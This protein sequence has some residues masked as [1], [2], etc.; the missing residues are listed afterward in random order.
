MSFLKDNKI[1]AVCFDIDGTLY[2]IK[3]MNAYLFK[4]F[5]KHPIFS[6]KYNNMRQKMRKL[7]GFDK[8]ET[9]SKDD[10]R[11]KEYRILYNKFNQVK[12]DKYKKDLETKFFKNWDRDVKNLNP[13]NNMKESLE[14]LKKNGYTVAVLSDFPLS[15]KL[16]A[17][18]IKD[19]IDYAASSEDFGYLKP[20]ATVFHALAS[21]LKLQPEEILFVGDS[22]HKDVLG[23]SNIGMKTMLINKKEKEENN[24][25]DFQLSSFDNFIKSVL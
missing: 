7:D 4:S 19:L 13:Y 12:F 8:K 20:N 1:K 3:E 25:A 11:E 17:L 21:E 18:G 15:F 6:I 16:E 24:M 5:I 9:L 23:A 14:E 2:P 10:F 22:Y